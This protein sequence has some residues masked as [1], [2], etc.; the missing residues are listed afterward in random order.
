MGSTM[1][2]YIFEWILDLMDEGWGLGSWCNSESVCSK[3]S[4]FLLRV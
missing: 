1:Y 3:C 4:C 2:I